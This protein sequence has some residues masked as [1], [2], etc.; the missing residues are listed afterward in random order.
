MLREDLIRRARLI[1]KIDALEDGNYLDDDGVLAEINAIADENDRLENEL[2]ESKRRYADAF[3][4]APRVE[5]KDDA[6]VAEEKILVE[7]FLDL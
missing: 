4:N 6:E 1:A 2:G 5:E 7:D 3:F